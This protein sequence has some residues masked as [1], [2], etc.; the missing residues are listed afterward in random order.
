MVD[1]SAE[2]LAVSRMLIHDRSKGKVKASNGIMAPGR[3]LQDKVALV[4]GGGSGK[5]T[6]VR[7]SCRTLI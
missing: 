4:T 3:L 7:L 5:L 1:S 6:L 2:L